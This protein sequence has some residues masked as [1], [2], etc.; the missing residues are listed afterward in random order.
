M[1]LGI[2]TG[3]TYTDAVVIDPATHQVLCKSKELTTKGCLV[4]GIKTCIS[5]LQIRDLH[6]IRLVCLS[7]TLAT[8]AVVEGRKGRVG[9]IAIGKSPGGSLPVEQFILIKGIFDIKGRELEPI[10]DDQIKEAIADLKTSGVEAVCIS[11]YASVRNPAHELEAKKRITNS[12]DIPVVCAHELSSNL[13]FKDRTVTAALNTGLISIIRELIISVRTVLTQ[14]GLDARLMIVKGDGSLMEE[15]YALLK[16]IETILSGPAASIL[17]GLFLSGIKD[18]VILD[19]GGTT[20]DIAEVSGGKV[21]VK[22]EGAVVGGFR[23]HVHAAR[24]HTFGIGGDSY[25]YLDSEQK[26]QIGPQKVK[27]LCVAG[28]EYP[29]LIEE[30]IKFHKDLEYEFFPNQKTDCFAYLQEKAGVSLN[31]LDEQVIESLQESPHSLL[32]LSLFFNKDVEAFGLSR[33]VGCGLIERI[34]ITP[35]DLLHVLGTYRQ[36]NCD[37]AIKGVEILAEKT[38]QSESSFIDRVISILTDQLMLA[39]IESLSGLELNGHA[40]DFVEK[41][42]QNNSSSVEMNY[43]LKKPIVAIGAPVMAWLPSVAYQLDAEL[44]IPEHAEVA[45]AV[46]AATGQVRESV[47][48][49]IRNDKKNEGFAVHAPWGRT[50]LYSL[51]GALDYSLTEARK[52]VTALVKQAGSPRCELVD[53]FEHVYTKSAVAEYKKYIETRVNVVGLGSP[54]WN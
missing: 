27:P 21:N 53:S 9:L 15:S 48:V 31:S 14:K 54:E 45:N 22:T 25:I 5:Q 4:S 26:I 35:T 49:L 42:L 2:D 30:L 33:L 28:N 29:N 17:G 3:G 19:M 24:I 16:P 41:I 38:G 6:K 11:G 12:W 47:E 13:G 37:I 46:G 10:S 8:N 7:T 1:I 43:R 52:Y 44:I 32:Y 23:T 39:V 40:V 18:A 20:T 51:D 36:W 50:I 34:S